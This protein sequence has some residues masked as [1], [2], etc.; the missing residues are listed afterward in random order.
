MASFDSSSTGVD[1]APA[2][3]VDVCKMQA[4][5]LGGFDDLAHAEDVGARRERAGVPGDVGVHVVGGLDE[6]SA[7][8]ERKRPVSAHDLDADGALFKALA[9]ECL[10]LSS[11]GRHRAAVLH[12]REPFEHG[13]VDAGAAG[14]RGF[15]NLV[16]GARHV[17]AGLVTPAAAAMRVP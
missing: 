10:E 15:E 3:G 2:V 17:E 5:P 7:R 1:A 6:L 4:L 14:L 16:D 13:D 9:D 8:L 12:G 11:R